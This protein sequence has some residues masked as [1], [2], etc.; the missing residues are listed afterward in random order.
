MNMETKRLLHDKLL[1]ANQILIERMHE[2]K[3]E[4][5]LKKILLMSN[6]LEKM[7]FELIW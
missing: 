1:E 4:E 5:K 3:E 7:M 6:R 2:T